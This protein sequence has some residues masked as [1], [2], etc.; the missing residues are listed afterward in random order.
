MGKAHQNQKKTAQP[1]SETNA[2]ASRKMINAI[3]GKQTPIFFFLNSSTALV[4][5]RLFFSFL[6]YS[7]HN[8][9][10]SLNE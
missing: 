3:K 5:P 1:K 4:G 6:I 2:L 10:D 9:Q 8:R 7:I